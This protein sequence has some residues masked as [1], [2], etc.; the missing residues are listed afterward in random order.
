MNEP[1]AAVDALAEAAVADIQS[2][3]IV[4]LGTGRTASRGVLALAERVRNHSLNIRCV[5]TSHVTQTLAM[6]QGLTLMDFEMLEHVDY[7]FDGADE[8]DDQMRILK[9]GGGAMTRER[10]VA[11]A[12]RRC[13]YMVTRDKLVDRLGSKNTLGIA[14]LTFGLSSVRAQLR[15][16]G[17]NG[18]VRRTFDGGLF[19]TDNGNVILDVSI[20]DRDVNELSQLLNDIPGVVDH[21]LFLTEADELII[22]T[23]TGVERRIREG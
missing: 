20:G 15:N 1:A 17:L 11:W 16:L 12:S 8:V 5:P 13:V 2:G 18:V 21:G 7:L 10:I 4:G 19:L 23:P 3:M 22:E 9:G 14:V 6:S